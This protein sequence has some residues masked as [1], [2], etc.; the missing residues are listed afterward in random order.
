MNPLQF[1][2]ARRESPT[3]NLSALIDII[4]I[5]VIFVVLVANFDRLRD[6]DVTL[7]SATATGESDARALV[8]TIRPEGPLQLD[9]EE[10]EEAA[11]GG[12][13]RELRDRHEALLVVA[14]GQVALERAVKV[15]GE[16][17]AAGFTAVS[18]ATREAGR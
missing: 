14:D 8:V 15:L 6:I 4:F 18:I 12:R 17:S 2:T 7:P 11:L 10:V 9:D 3:I 1:H 16:A 5:L 13:L